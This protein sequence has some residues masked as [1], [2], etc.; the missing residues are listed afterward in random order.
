[1]ITSENYEKWC[2]ASANLNQMM[3]ELESQRE[4]NYSWICNE[5]KEFF[6]PFEIEKV[7]ITNDGSIIN[8]RFNTHRVSLDFQKL[9]DLPFK[10]K[11]VVDE[12]LC[13]RLYT[14]LM[15]VD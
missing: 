1:M 5:I 11:F 6:I 7:S 8:V 13:L 2:D 12:G 3:A 14:D 15:E 9:A 10:G 4:E